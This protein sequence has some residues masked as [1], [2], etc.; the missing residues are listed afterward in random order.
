MIL[1]RVP[2]ICGERIELHFDGICNVRFQC[3][4]VHSCFFSYTSNFEIFI[5][6]FSLMVCINNVGVSFCIRSSPTCF[7][8]HISLLFSSVR[9]FFL[10]SRLCHPQC[11]PP[12]INVRE[13]ESTCFFALIALYVFRVQAIVTF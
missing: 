1:Y 12:S 10:S 2:R 8:L 6:S 9:I 11:F 13:R 3:A 5:S 4:N 7:P